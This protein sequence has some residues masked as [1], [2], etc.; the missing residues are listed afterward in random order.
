MASSLKEPDLYMEYDLQFHAELA[1]ATQNTVLSVLIQPLILML[2][3]ARRILASVPG[4]AQRSLDC[5]R[6]IYEAITRR[7][8]D[9]AERCMRDHLE[10]V[11]N[12]RIRARAS[13]T[14]KGTAQD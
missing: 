8:P 13:S 9:A 3:S 5:H 10:Q 2:Q 4:K 6:R 1:R 14:V 11:A 12:D 7:D